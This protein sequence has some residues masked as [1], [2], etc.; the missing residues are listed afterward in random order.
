MNVKAG[1]ALCNSIEAEKKF[2]I[3]KD[4]RIWDISEMCTL[5]VHDTDEVVSQWPIVLNKSPVC[6]T[7]LVTSV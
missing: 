4:R 7:S 6:F 5:Y 2:W 3:C 1:I